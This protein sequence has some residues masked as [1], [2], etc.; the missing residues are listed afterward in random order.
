[1]RLNSLKIVVTVALAALLLLALAG[2]AFAAPP[3]SDAP[4]A[5]WEAGYE[6][7]EAEVATVADGYPDGTF[8]PSVAVT[9][10]Q[11]A[12]MAMNGLEVQTANPA[13]PTF[14]DVA[15]N[16]IFYPYVEGAYAAG[17]IGG[18]STGGSLYFKP[19]STITRQQA[20]SI[21]GRY[22][23]KVEIDTTGVV[24]GDVTNYGTLALWY[25]AEGEFYLKAFS[26][27]SK[28][29]AEHRATTAYLIR[30]G[31]VKGSSSRLDPTATLVRSQAAVLVL[32]VKAEAVDILT[33][34]PPPTNLGV[35]ATG[36]GANVTQTGAAQYVGNDPTPRVTGETLADSDIAIY[37]APFY[38]TAYIKLDTTNLSGR[39]YADLDEPTKPLADGTH[40][41]TAKVM[42][43]NGLVSRASDAVSYVLDTVLPA[44]A[45]TAPT[46]TVGQSYAVADSVKPAFTVAAGDERSGVERVEFQVARDILPLEWHTIS[47]DTA[48]ETGT[49]T[50][51]AVW[52]AGGGLGAG[53][54][55]G[56]YQFRAVVT[57]VAGNQRT[58]GPLHVVVAVPPTAVITAPVPNSGSVFYTE[59]TTPAFTAT[60]TDPGSAG[61]ENIQKVEFLYA[62]WSDPLPNTWAQFSLLSADDTAAYAATYMSPLAEG[63]YIFAV[64]ATDKAGNLSAL[65]DGSVYKAN[66]T[67]EVIIDRTAP[68]ITITAPTA[69]QLVP[70]AA[71]LAITWTLTDIPAVSTPAAVLIEYSATGGDPWTTIA[72]PAPFTP[73][74]PGSF[75]W[76]VPH[77]TGADVATFKI[78]ITA[79]DKAAVPVGN[80]AAHTTVK[81][82]DAFTVYDAPAPAADVA[83]NDPDATEADVDGRDFHAIWTLSTSGHIVLQELYLLPDP[84]TLDLTT[85][86]AET[87]VASFPNNATTTWTGTA[88]LDKNSLGDRLTAGDYRFWVVVTDPAGRKAVSTASDPFAVTAE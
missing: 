74:L 56:D 59:S 47:T 77:I 7:T 51:A 73:G 69:G 68:L 71:S 26:D 18:Y 55:D 30:R 22:L 2:G 9:R 65:M 12:K 1:M 37:D 66:V 54:A 87:P 6:V 62:L 57:D 34:P 84:K 4:A 53:L 24:H 78:R 42:N 5:W 82:S 21:L 48:P 83:G 39:F 80:I 64:R 29:A 58:L 33:P 76:T 10:G 81:T 45:V 14:K 20:N 19:G 38:G 43:A 13:T 60:A 67:Q 72:A 75:L 32:R 25:N 15:K 35:A 79:V 44:G 11:F 70:D 52:P 63:R 49:T 23:S 28:V 31:I 27:W 88:S 85:A 40:S 8:R 17:L 16:H 41:F 3:W 36:A 46:V 50:Y 61:V 86:P